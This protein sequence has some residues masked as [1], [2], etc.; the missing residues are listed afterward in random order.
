MYV[1]GLVTHGTVNT[2]PFATIEAFADHGV[3]E[4]DTVRGSASASRA[5][6]DALRAEGIDLDEVF[7]LLEQQ[8]VEKFVTAWDGLLD[9]VKA[10]IDE[11]QT[12]S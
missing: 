6:L 7:A 8:G 12:S 11:M 5:T 9:T 4:S 1:T 2:M 10:R 3:V